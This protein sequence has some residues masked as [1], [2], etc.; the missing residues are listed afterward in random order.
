MTTE[1]WVE[2][3]KAAAVV[4]S[5]I[6]GVASYHIINKIKDTLGLTSSR[7]IQ[8]LTAIVATVIALLSLIVAGTLTPAPINLGYI[9]QTFTL[10]L[11]AS[12]AEYQRIKR[13]LFIDDIVL[14]EYVSA[15]E[16]EVIHDTT[17]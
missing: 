7:H 13:Q 15:E 3:A 2:V 8:V 12:Q 5:I 9:V 17:G 11:V 4:L 6:G 14:E 16:H 10:V 1:V